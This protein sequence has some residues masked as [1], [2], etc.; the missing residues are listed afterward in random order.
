MLVCARLRLASVLVTPQIR[1]K[2]ISKTIFVFKSGMFN[3]FETNYQFLDTTEFKN[4]DKSFLI[5]TKE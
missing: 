5:C 1:A 2:G 4:Y 3:Y